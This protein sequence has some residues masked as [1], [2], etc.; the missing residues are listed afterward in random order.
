MM[1]LSSSACGKKNSVKNTVN[2]NMKTYYEINDGSWMCDDYIYKYRL[3]ISGRMP[4]A[5]VDSTF[6]YLSNIEEISFERAYM[7]AGVSSNTEDYFQP[8]EAVLVEM[9]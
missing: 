3:E 5:A 8:E 1:I 7:A 9:K 2:G 4:S 6:V